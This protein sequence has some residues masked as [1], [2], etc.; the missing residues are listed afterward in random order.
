MVHLRIKLYTYI[1]SQG[2]NSVKFVIAFKHDH[3]A[4][5]IKGLQKGTNILNQNWILL[6][7]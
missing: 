6:Q 2:Q 1:Y 5:L 4:A 7:E 3:I